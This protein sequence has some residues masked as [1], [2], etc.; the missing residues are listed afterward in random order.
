MAK[1]T[2]VKSNVNTVINGKSWDAGVPVDV[3]DTE[4]DGLREHITAGVLEIVTVEPTETPSGIE[5]STDAAPSVPVVD[6]AASTES[7]DDSGSA[8]EG[9]DA[10]TVQPPAT[11][12]ASTTATRR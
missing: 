2:R 3:P 6:P 10:G 9:T 4:I 5:S 11:G 1:T 7:A 12:S 8:T